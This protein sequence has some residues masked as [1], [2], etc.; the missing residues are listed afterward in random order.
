MGPAR[1]AIA[2]QEGAG[3]PFLV[4]GCAGFIGSRVAGLL[5]D[6]GHAV[7]GVDNLNAAYDP[8]LKQHRVG[9]LAGRPGF[10]F[11]AL[12]IT[13]RPAL[14]PLFAGKQFRGVFN[15]AARAGVRQ[16][17]QDP[18]AYLDTNATGTL[19]VLDLARRHDVR[20]VLVASTSSLYGSHNPTPFREDAN[21]DRPLS[22][23]AASKK[24]AEA[25]CASYAHLYGMDTP[26]PRYFTVYGPAGRPDM[27][28]FRFIRWIAEEKPLVVYGDGRQERSFTYVDDIA[29][30]SI[31]AL[32]RVKGFELVNLGSDTAVALNDMIASIE[33]HLGKKA[34]I[35]RRPF[36]PADVQKTRADI[37]KARQL[38][39]WSPQVSFE[40]GVKAT[41]GWYMENRALAS[42]LDLG[43]V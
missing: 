27:S 23:Y 13:D 25:M 11:H 32:E 1:P 31:A 5:L 4:T 2:K 21:T 3:D 43:E 38:L 40:E 15:L 30:G 24:A 12:D 39:D 14:Q 17:M 19:N 36:H 41:V 9:Q 29:R 6:A 35:E 26:V 28:M 7:V 18:W 37:G 34:R 16:S 33:G 42:T 22:P 20:R 8:R 10:A